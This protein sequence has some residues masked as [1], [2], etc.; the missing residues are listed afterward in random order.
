MTDG[1]HLKGRCLCRAVGI[2]AQA[3]NLN[4][5]ACHCSM[6]RKWGGGPFLAISCA[7]AITFEGEDNIAT[8]ASSS[9]AERGFCKLCG[10]HLFYRLKEATEYEIPIGLLDEV[11]DIIL[12]SQIYID[13]KPPYYTFAEQ[14]QILTEAEVMAQYVM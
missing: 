11:P 9:W 14:T 10:T 13:R 7:E 12:T 4:I 3:A 1:V 8:F 5:T 2:E 6:C